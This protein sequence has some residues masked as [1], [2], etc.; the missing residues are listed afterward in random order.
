[1]RARFLT[2]AVVTA[3]VTL[4]SLGA[5]AQPAAS[6]YVMQDPTTKKCTIVEKKPVATE[7]IIVSPDGTVYKT[8]TEAEGAIKTIKVCTHD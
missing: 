7:G 8:R 3:A 2:A 6:F 5:F 4:P 1:M